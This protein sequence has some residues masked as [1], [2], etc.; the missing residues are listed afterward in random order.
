MTAFWDK[1]DYF[2]KK[3][4]E[5]ALRGVDEKELFIQKYR[6]FR[7]VLH[8]NQEVLLLIG[9]MQEKASGAFVFDRAYIESSYH[10]VSQGIKE[11]IDNLNI[12][13]DGKYGNLIIPFK[14][15]D[16][17]IRNR[18]TAKISIPVTDYIIFLKALRKEDALAAGGKFA[19]LGEVAQMLSIPVPP[20]FVITTHAN[21][22]FFRKNKLE[23]R[24]NDR[25]KNID[26]RNYEAL[27]EASTEIV[28]MVK[29]CPIP[30]EIAQ[31]ILDSYEKLCE[32]T[33][34]WN[35]KV[36][37]RSSAVQEDILASFAGQYE[38]VLNVPGG[39]LLDQYKNVLASLFTPRALFYYRNKGFALEEM[40]MA[41]GVLSMVDSRASGIIYSRDPQNQR[42]D[43]L[44]VS[45]VWG[46]G[47]YAVR[48]EGP[49]D[50]Y[51]VA[52]REVLRTIN[53]ESSR[54]GVMV[55]PDDKSGTRIAP[56][57]KKWIGKPC[58]DDKQVLKLAHLA[59]KVEE[60][61]GVPQDIEW[62]LDASGRLFLLQARPLRLPSRT[63][64]PE[65]RRPFKVQDYPVLLDRGTIACQGV[66]AGTVY[67]VR[68]EEDL[69]GFPDGGVLVIR[70]AYPEFAPALSKASAVISDSGSIL[71][72]LATVARE[73]NVPA[74]FNT[75]KASQ[76]LRNGMMVTVD[77]VYAT[78]YEG[79]VKG[80][81]DEQPKSKTW[82]DSPA[83]KEL[84][85][86]LQ[87]ITPLHLTDPRSP[88]FTPLK[89]Q[90]LHDITRFAHEISLRVIFSLSKESH[91]AE[92]STRQLVSNVPLKWW[93]IDLEDGIAPG[94]KG[95]KVTLQE[96]VSIPL[97]AL[98]Q[99]MLAQPWKGPPPVDMK[100]FLSVMFSATMDPSIE[101][102][103]GIEFADKNYILISKNFCNVSTRLGFHF[104]TI[105]AFV[106]E[107]DNENYLSFVYTG[108]GAEMGRKNRRVV[109]LSRILE[110]FDFRVEK[111]EDTLF[112][113][114]EGYPKG[115]MEG[116]LKV[117]G[118]IVI[119]TRQLDMVMVNDAVV[120]WYYQE[121]MKD[122]QPLVA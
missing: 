64:G 93:V 104:S 56:V 105:E 70:H 83:L 86:I 66:G 84:R 89:C 26:L 97:C 77:A 110:T 4:Q 76:V 109:M 96:I 69:A 91:F 50:N 58:L 71:S 68:K 23:N 121:L 90:T 122:L 115:F 57:P 75:E 38:S 116:R 30:S 80:L 5:K 118:F 114:Y 85:D 22:I 108:G 98:W 28:E 40:A 73:Y 39:D 41:V 107:H 13:A 10:S 45:A 100:G 51:R 52:K 117:L 72:H 59:R 43:T 74:V 16:T 47:I 42:E 11:I 87:W 27:Q 17:A 29:G 55:A 54:Q 65:A 32:L 46:L 15:T 9:D 12:L 7:E 6:A 113:R 119:H 36:S 63:T 60:H 34:Q 3:R 101:P 99:G 95:K 44:L 79:I 24:L 61:F 67:I 78:I 53:D 112:A 21:Q 111:K 14:K 81:L 49:S 106:G 103:V 20:G 19:L 102:S 1:F 120:D 25:M 92:R 48:G 88:E 94:S 82:E 33:H 62:A 37:V 2:S 35:L 18:L 31:A 8:H